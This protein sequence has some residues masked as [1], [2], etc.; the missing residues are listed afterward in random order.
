MGVSANAVSTL[1]AGEP[2]ARSLAGVVDLHC[3]TGPDVVPRAATDFE[4]VRRARAE[5]MRA[6]VLKNHYTMTADRA[7]LA[8]LEVGGIEVFGGIV[9]NRSVGGINAE[10]VR[11]MT[12]MAGQRGKIVWLPTVDAE[13][14]VR[15]ARESR[16]FIAVVDNGKPVPELA[17]VFQLIAQHDL[18]LATGH[19]GGEESIILIASAR[20]AGVRP[21]TCHPRARGGNWS[22]AGTPPKNG[23]AGC[24]DGMHLAL[25]LQRS[26]RR[27]QRW[28]AC[29]GENMCRHGAANRS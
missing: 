26:R 21:D 5:G 3:H 2:A 4:L 10:A 24:T 9:L 17:E 18:V 12:Q 29:A 7:Q 19:S 27:D 22:D 28:P 16:P 25:A 6:L 13:S 14:Q 11:R 23:P 15:F 1:S 8:M 20:Q